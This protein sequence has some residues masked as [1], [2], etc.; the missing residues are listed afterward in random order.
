MTGDPFATHQ[1][2]GLDAGPIRVYTAGP[3][4]APPVLLLHGA[5]LDTAPLT[6]RHLMPALAASRRVIAV[7][8]PRHGG[9]R[10]WS[11]VLDQAR[12]EDVLTGLLDRL[13]LARVDVVGLSMGG[14]LA[15]GLALRRPE[16]VR[17]L[18]LLAPGG[19]DE[20]RPWQFAT[21]LLLRIGA[22]PRWTAAWL[23][24]SPK[25][26]RAALV[27]EHPAGERTPDFAALVDLVHAEARAKRAHREGAFDDWQVHAYGP[28]RMRLNHLPRLHLLAVPSLWLRGEHDTLVPEEVVRRAAAAAPGGRFASIEGAGHVSPLDRPDRVLELV[29]GFLGELDTAGGPA[30]GPA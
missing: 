8:L 10:P 20:V 17:G 3:P 15:V 16:R 12:L 28:R 18:V 25:A 9:S 19:L 22:V 11:G 29:D 24:A 5:M 30:S 4:D 26:V 7:D 2:I 6:W 21:W 13:G 1:D 14:G 27:R 23:A